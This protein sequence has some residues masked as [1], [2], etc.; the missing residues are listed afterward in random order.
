[1]AVDIYDL[2]FWEINYSLFMTICLLPRYIKATD[3][4]DVAVWIKEFIHLVGGIQI[5]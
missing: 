3:M 2:D 4:C 5:H 1:M